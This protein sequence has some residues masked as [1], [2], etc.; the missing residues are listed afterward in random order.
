MATLFVDKIDPQSGTSLEIGSSG[1]TITIPSGATMVNNGTQTGFGGTNTPAFSVKKSSNQ[2]IA[3]TTT[4]KMEL[5]SKFFDTD[6]KYDNSTNYRFT[7]GVAGKYFLYATTAFQNFTSNRPITV[8]IRKNGSSI[9]SFNNI[10][11]S[12]ADDF[13][14]VI[15]T[16]AE[17]NTTDYFEAFCFHRG[18][19]SQTM[20]GSASTFGGYKI[21]E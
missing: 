15:T 10:N 8:H 13:S 21:I 16:I 2:T 11:G 9:A 12:Y 4:T 18:G 14:A 5:D 7:P 19:S 20:I 1:D 3:D 17:A 6:N